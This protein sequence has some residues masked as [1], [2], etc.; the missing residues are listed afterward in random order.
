GSTT[1]LMINVD[2]VP[3]HYLVTVSG[4]ISPCALLNN[5]VTLRCTSTTPWTELVVPVDADCNYTATLD[6]PFVSGIIE[7]TTGCSNGSVPVENVWYEVPSGEQEVSYTRDLSCT[8]APAEACFT[9]EQQAPFTAW[10]LNCSMGCN[11][12]YT[13]LWDIS[14]P[15]GG[16]Q[17]G[18]AVLYTF[19]GPG[20]YAVCLN[21][22]GADGCASSI[23]HSVVVAIDGTI[24]PDS[25]CHA[26]FTFEPTAPFTAVATTCS[27]GGTEPYTYL[28]DFS[29]GITISGQPMQY[30]LTFAGPGTY[31]IC[32]T[33]SNADGCVSDTCQEVIVNDDGTIMPLTSATYQVHVS[34]HVSP[35]TLLDN[36]VTVRC[37]SCTPWVEQVVTVDANCDYNATL[38]VDELEGVVVVATGC[39]NGSVPN[40]TMHYI[41]NPSVGETSLTLNLNCDPGPSQACFTVEQTA[42]F[43]ATF[44]NCSTGCLPPF[45]FVWDFSD[46]G[47]VEGDE[48][49]HTFPG[50]G[51]YAVCLNVTG[52]DGCIGQSCQEVV[53]G[54][55]G[56]INPDPNP[57]EASFW[58]LQAYENDPSSGD[59][60]P[61]PGV[62]WVW[63]LSSGNGP[64][65][66]A[67]D[68]GD[69][70]SS[71]DPFPT[72]V[73]EGMG[74]YNLCLT[75]TGGGCT[76]TYCDSVEVDEEGFLREGGFTISVLHEMPTG[77]ADVAAVSDIKA[78]PNPVV[79]ELNIAV[80]S[81]LKGVVDVLVT[82]LS[83]RTILS[84]PRALNT[85]SNTLRLATN[86]LEPGMYVVRVG[87]KAHGVTQRFVKTR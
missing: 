36:T 80:S 23:C 20:V 11:A 66:F 46:A 70:T 60:I 27:T 9:V 31:S 38:T 12:P 61:V 67:W 85:G 21:F 69:G 19:P 5:T 40:N 50:P 63:N 71:T 15:G 48:V 73:Y 62:L 37:T 87:D 34:G 59:P 6:L 57:C 7:V 33:F 76:N 83:G 32:H 41:V 84:E 4:H 17:T 1:D 26:C 54:A 56:T 79:D 55:D 43:T 78:W 86:T 25:P 35:C 10:F 47:A 72:H 29:N 16:T 82:D 42:P 24:N 28:W 22:S 65:T 81:T 49:T 77:I 58:V 44:S 14:G 74:P 53:V 2:C 30:T 8:A 64:F 51:V 13:Y 45:T 75:I 3:T 52:A 39:S 18:D 68:F